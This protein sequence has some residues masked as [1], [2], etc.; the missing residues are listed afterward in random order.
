MVWPINFDKF[1]IETIKMNG[2]KNCAESFEIIPDV[3]KIQLNIFYTFFLKT[4][5]STW[6]YQLI[7]ENEAEIVAAGITVTTDTSSKRN[8]CHTNRYS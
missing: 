1:E 8:R 4:I 2:Q 6:S 5:F 3:V 7:L